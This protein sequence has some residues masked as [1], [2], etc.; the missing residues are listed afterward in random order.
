[1]K[2]KLET[3]FQDTEIGKIP[4]E[5][6]I[7][8]LKDIGKIVSGFTFPLELQG[9]NSGRYPFIKVNDMNNSYKYIYTAENYVDDNDLVKLKARPYPPNTIIFP[10]TGM[11]VR[12]N[13]YRILGLEALFDNNIAGV[14]IN[15]KLAYYEFIYYYLQGKIDLM[16]LA[17]MTTVPSIT[18]TKLENIPIPYPSIHEQRRI[19]DILSTVDRVIEGVDVAIARLEGLKRALMRE[20]LSGRI[21]VRE[22]NGKLVFYRETE[23]QKAEI[24]KM[25]REWKVV[26]LRTISTFAKRGKTPK[27]GNSELLV[28]KTA[29]NY[30][31]GIRFE[32]AP[33]ASE[34]FLANLPKEF[35]LKLGDILINS[36]GT[37][38]V[39]RVGF[40]ESYH[41]P[42]TVDGHITI[43]RVDQNVVIPKY[44]FYYLS[45]PSGQRVL[46]SKVSGSTHQVELYVNEIL[47]LALP[48]QS[49]EEQQRIV[50]I[51][52]MIDQAIKL[53]REE[54]IRLDHLKRSLMDLLLSGRVR[55]LG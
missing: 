55:V 34:E 5:W 49:L 13:K 47:D 6:K 9:K 52:S 44:V 26:K 45:S 43:L 42:C 22:E 37:G 20:L 53:Y 19:A 35:Y 24:G 33:Q 17:S 4:R 10:K 21:R 39:G 15:D 46:L 32:E 54:R 41:K 23:F 51:F 16:S 48:L 7:A 40:F 36:T 2:F 30:P 29:H 31:D 1:V 28:I 11:A 3:E 18:K 8:K 50:E 38:S 14:I 12:L 27:Y 25:P